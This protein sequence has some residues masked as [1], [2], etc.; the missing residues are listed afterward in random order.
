MRSL[1]SP[2]NWYGSPFPVILTWPEMKQNKDLLISCVGLLQVISQC[3][4]A[5]KTL[6]MLFISFFLFLKKSWF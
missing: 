6:K 4:C 5:Q 2:V 3:K 1:L